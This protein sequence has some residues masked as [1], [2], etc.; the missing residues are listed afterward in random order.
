MTRLFIHS[1][2]D[3]LVKIFHSIS[4]VSSEIKV[5]EMGFSVFN[6]IIECVIP[7]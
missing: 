1:V 4:D 5:S 7:C 6:G 3:I 2:Y